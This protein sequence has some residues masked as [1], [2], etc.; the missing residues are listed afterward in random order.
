[1]QFIILLNDLQRVAVV[2][3]MKQF[4]VPMYLDCSLCSYSWRIWCYYINRFL[5]SV[6]WRCWL[7]GRKGIQPVNWVVGCWHGYVWVTV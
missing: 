4:V 5:P 2:G 1:V 7:G 3:N 6:L